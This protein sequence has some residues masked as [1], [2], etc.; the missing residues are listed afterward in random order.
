MA[1]EAGAFCTYACCASP[2]SRYWLRYFPQIY[3]DENFMGYEV[4][5]S[6][7]INRS[8]PFDGQK[9]I[10]A[11]VCLIKQNGPATICVAW[12][13]CEKSQTHRPFLLENPKLKNDSSFRISFSQPKKIRRAHVSFQNLQGNIFANRS[14][15]PKEN[16]RNIRSAVIRT[17]T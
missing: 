13:I 2:S 12:N 9:S 4:F 5:K 10:P 17:G 6:V 11:I 15:S 3:M 7:T 1:C 8:S 14:S 16:G